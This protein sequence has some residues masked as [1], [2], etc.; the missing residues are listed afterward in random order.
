MK[1]F[2]THDATRTTATCLLPTTTPPPACHAAPEKEKRK[3]RRGHKIE[4]EER[5]KEEE[6]EGKGRDMLWHGLSFMGDRMSCW[7]D[8]ESRGTTMRLMAG[9]GGGL[10]HLILLSDKPA[11]GEVGCSGQLP[12]TCFPLPHCLS[13]HGQGLLL[14][15]L[16]RLW[17]H[18]RQQN[19][20][21]YHIF[22]CSLL[23]SSG[24][25][26]HL[27]CVDELHGKTSWQNSQ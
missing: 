22:F 25:S 24:I 23:L 14:S 15:Q 27:F 18:L 11:Y 2:P 5:K 7:E 8:G 26:L 17:Y 12:P 10:R 20:K 6:E 4:K 9:A 19:H 13:W 16:S 3:R 21:T 1:D